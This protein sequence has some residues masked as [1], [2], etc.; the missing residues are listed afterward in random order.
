MCNNGVACD[1]SGKR[2][3]LTHPAATKKL[4][5]VLHQ[6]DFTLRLTHNTHTHTQ[7]PSFCICG[8]RYIVVTVLPSGK[9][10]SVHILTIIIIITLLNFSQSKV[11]KAS[12]CFNSSI[13]FYSTIKLVVDLICHHITWV[14][15]I[16]FYM[17]KIKSVF[18]KFHFYLFF[19]T[20]YWQISILQLKNISSG[21]I[22][23]IIYEE[24]KKQ[25]KNLLCFK[26]D[27]KS[28]STFQ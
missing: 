28:D 23:I 11:W 12:Y 18:T 2:R 22:W 21:Y 9:I 20:K 15:N 3:A 26:P 6:V 19:Q 13:S 8:I 17:H 1:K 14:F 5:I 27:M 4:Q 16:Q 24:E 10:H 7:F 25:P